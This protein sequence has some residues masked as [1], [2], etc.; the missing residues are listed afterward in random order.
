MWGITAAKL[1][2]K[3]CIRAN[4]EALYPNIILRY[5]MSIQPEILYVHIVH[6]EIFLTFLT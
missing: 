2:E 6:D 1:S 4:H 3:P 5:R